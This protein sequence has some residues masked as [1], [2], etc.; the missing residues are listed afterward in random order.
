MKVIEI[1]PHDYPIRKG[2]SWWLV[3]P[4]TKNSE[5]FVPSGAIAFCKRA[6]IAGDFKA[7]TV[8]TV[9][10]NKPNEGY[11]TV[12]SKSSVVTMPYYVFARYFD[13]EA[14][15]RGRFPLNETEAKPFDYKPTIP[16]FKG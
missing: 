13:A 5:F 2:E 9:T 15:V 12:M 4:N 8:Y 6:F 1:D 11:L 7:N 10:G 3:H 16:A 14:F